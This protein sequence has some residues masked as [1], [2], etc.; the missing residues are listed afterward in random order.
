MVTGSGL[1]M[2]ARVIGKVGQQRH[3]AG[4]HGL[5]FVAKIL[6][7]GDRISQVY[8]DTLANVALDAAPHQKQAG[9]GEAGSDEQ[10][11][12]QKTRAQAER[13]AQRAHAD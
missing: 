9:R 5:A 2:M 13:G 10:H 1:V 4:Q 11:G 3:V 7:R 12:E 6:E 8:G